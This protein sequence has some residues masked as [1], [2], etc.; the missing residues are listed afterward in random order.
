MFSVH[1][2]G[3][4]FNQFSHTRA[5]TRTHASARRHRQAMS[6]PKSISICFFTASRL[7]KIIAI[8]HP[9]LLN[10]ASV[11]PWSVNNSGENQPC[12]QADWTIMVFGRWLEWQFQGFVNVWDVFHAWQNLATL[13]WTLQPSSWLSGGHTLS[14]SHQLVQTHGSKAALPKN[15]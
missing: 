11:Q 2:L 6:V 4:C 8:S 14:K 9:P 1:R 3:A 12:H 15:K 7:F 13:S 10:A 5:R